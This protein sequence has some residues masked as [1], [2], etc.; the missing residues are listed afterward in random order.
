M[1]GSISFGSE[2]VLGGHITK[3]IVQETSNE[4]RLSKFDNNTTSPTSTAWIEFHDQFLHLQD[5]TINDKIYVK[6]LT[7][8]EIQ[9]LQTD[10]T[11]ILDPFLSNF[12][13]INKQQQSQQV[14]NSPPPPNLLL[15]PSYSSDKVRSQSVDFDVLDSSPRSLH[16]L[17]GCGVLWQI[18]QTSN[19]N[20]EI[21]V[22]IQEIR[23]VYSVSF[24]YSHIFTAI[25]L[26]DY[27]DQT[28]HLDIPICIMV[29]YY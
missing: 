20:D 28:F 25:A 27:L 7:Y 6:E 13:I 15:S 9:E 21:K 26:K 10:S 12:T 18:E 24:Q 11:F 29:Y 17:S 22:D 4:R 14:L 1:I 19:V 16:Q 23:A 8:L 5:N 3:E 2:I